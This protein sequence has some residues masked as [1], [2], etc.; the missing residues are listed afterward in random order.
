LSLKHSGQSKD[1]AERVP[2]DI[3]IAN[4]QYFASEDKMRIVL[5]GLRGNDSISELC[6]EAHALDEL[7][8]TL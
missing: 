4:A 5:G 1:S 3:R 2:K 8:L 6:H 7:V